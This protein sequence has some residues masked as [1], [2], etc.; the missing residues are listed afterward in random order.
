MPLK[1]KAKLKKELIAGIKTMV[2]IVGLSPTG[3]CFRHPSEENLAWLKILEKIC[4]E[5]SF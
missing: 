1:N 3:L 4:Y 2:D 5:L